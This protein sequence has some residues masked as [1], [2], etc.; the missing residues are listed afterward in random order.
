MEI[1][2]AEDKGW[3]DVAPPAPK[4]VNTGEKKSLFIKLAPRT[5][6]YRFRLIDN[7]I[8]FRQ[9]WF[10]LFVGLSK[11][12]VISPAY[13]DSQRDLDVAWGKGGH[14]PARHGAVPV[15]DRDDGEIRIL[16]ASSKEIFDVIYNFYVAAE[17]NPASN[18][19]PDFRVTVKKTDVKMVAGKE[20]YTTAISCMADP[21]YSHA[22]FTEQEL[23]KIEA[24]TLDWKKWFTKAAPAEIEAMW[25]QLPDEKKYNPKSKKKPAPAT[26]GTTAATAAPAATVATASAG[27]TV[28][29]A[30][31]TASS[32][33]PAPVVAEPEEAEEQEAEKPEEL[34][35]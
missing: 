14:I 12:P 7:P 30:A 27:T 4:T 22:P 13:E 16:E 1:V 9:H 24:F 32:S 34:P 17:I 21:K 29:S 33:S 35:F 20:K 23:E 31:H 5:E 15:I 2:K 6:P 25:N 19:G 28:A 11:K 26:A 10:G 3:D 18:N 8:M